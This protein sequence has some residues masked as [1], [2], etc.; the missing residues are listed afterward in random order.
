MY[1]DSVGLP[2]ILESTAV[3]LLQCCE[4][5]V[6]SKENTSENVRQEMSSMFYELENHK[7][8]FKELYSVFQHMMISLPLFG[9]GK[10]ST[11]TEGEK[12]GNIKSNSWGIF[13]CKMCFHLKLHLR[14]KCFPNVKFL[15]VKTLVFIF[16]ADNVRAGTS[17]IC[18][19]HTPSG[20]ICILIL[21]NNYHPI[22]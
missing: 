12:G 22:S 3:F 4:T 18:T 16:T 15:H 13:V 7:F 10:N 17:F 5:T 1:R 14:K 2:H 20:T 6:L 21:N 11:K 19:S 8:C 9:L